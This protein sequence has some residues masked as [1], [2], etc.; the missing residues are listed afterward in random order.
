MTPVFFPV[1]NLPNQQI[2][3]LMANFK[4]MSQYFE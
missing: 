1:G 2:N 4:T 3:S